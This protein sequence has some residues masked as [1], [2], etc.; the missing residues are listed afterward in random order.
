MPTLLETRRRV[1][2]DEG[3]GWEGEEEGGKNCFFGRRSGV[4]RSVE[5]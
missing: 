3:D 2:I 4:T 5:G 1:E